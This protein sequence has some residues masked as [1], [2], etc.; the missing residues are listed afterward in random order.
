M[1]GAGPRLRR[2]ALIL[3]CVP[4]LP[5]GCAA[6]GPGK[7]GR[8]PP[9]TAAG[10]ILAPWIS[11]NGAR[12]APAADAT[13]TPSLRAGPLVFQRF[14]HVAAVAVHDNDLYVVDSGVATVFRYDIGLGVMTPVAGVPA[15]HGTRVL[16]GGDFSL[17]VLDAQSRRVLR[18][19]RSGQVL[20]AYAAG[21]DLAHPVDLALEE[22]GGAVLV[23]DGALNQI[24][25]FHPLGRAWRVVTLRGDE[26]NRVRGVA[27]L[28]AGAGALYVSDPAC[29]CVARVA[30]DGA[31]L[32]TFGHQS[33]FQPGPIAL[34]R[35]GRVFVADRYD[36]TLK[37]FAEG[38]LARTLPAA[39][40]G[41]GQISDVRISDDWL[42]LAD[43]VNARVELLR[44]APPA[45]AER[46]AT[47]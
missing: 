34:D 37:I 21:S 12:V 32:D 41:L 1:V 7:P 26:R 47:P 23:A 29:G 14:V 2:W 39:A 36:Q 11:L 16:V 35:H 24:V 40:L 42:A 10:Q 5:G 15:H 3:A 27:A 43:G 28:A 31:V 13:G 44:I 33:V 20:A 38:R 30:R 18:F 8:S 19:S 25:S 22:P 45:A 17:Y 46:R 9:G 6:D 4:A